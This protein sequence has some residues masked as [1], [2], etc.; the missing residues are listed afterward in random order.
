MTFWI[1]EAALAPAVNPLLA[2][3]IK[4]Y[5]LV[6]FPNSRILFPLMVLPRDQKETVTL[7]QK[8]TLFAARNADAI[9]P[10]IFVTT[11]ADSVRPSDCETKH[12]REC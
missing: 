6:F 7:W 8:T 4:V 9:S 5:P 2:H 10:L 12:E 1:D 3:G 11:I